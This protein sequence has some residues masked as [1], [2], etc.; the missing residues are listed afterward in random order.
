VTVRS[1]SITSFERVLPRGRFRSLDAPDGFGSV[2]PSMPLGFRFGRPG[3]LLSRAISSRSAAT[4]RCNSTICS[5]C[6]TTK[7]FSSTGERRSRSSG[8][9]MPTKNPTRAVLGIL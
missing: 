4:S 7:P 2:P 1:S 8:A 5:H 3:L 6:L 9:C